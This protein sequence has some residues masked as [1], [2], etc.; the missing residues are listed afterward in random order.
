M[1]DNY[2]ISDILTWLEEKTL[3]VNQQ[4]QRSDQVWTQPAKA[5]LIDT[6]LRGLPMPPIYI[7]TETDPSTRRSFREVVDGQQR[8]L[9]I[10]S[11]VNDEFALG[12]NEEAYGENAGMK[13]SD[14]VPDTQKDFLG[15]QVP[16][17][18]LFNAPDAKVF[19]IFRRLNTY[20]FRLTHQELRHGRYQGHFRNAVLD[21]S[22]KWRVLWDRYG[23][24][25]KRARVRMADDELTAQ[26]FG[27]ILEGVCDG[28]QKAIEKL[29]KSFDSDL[30]V[31]ASLRLDRTVSY[32]LSDMEPALETALSTAPHFLMLFA[33]VA[34]V[35]DGLPAGDIGVE[36][37]PGRLGQIKDIPQALTNL[38]TLAGVLETDLEEVPDRFKEFKEA[39]LA[40]TQRIRSRKVRFLKLYSAL[41]TE[42]I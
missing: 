1:I 9:A 27:V 26:M 16:C 39:A 7:R 10:R 8:V 24:V 28:G 40:S 2:T 22:R 38:Q 4:Y 12:A 42:S 17:E 35:R 14:L 34:H 19:D 13:Y 15:Y 36:M 6:I 30:P 37:P 33:A 21:S 29:Y 20:N 11:F 25:N 5:Y 3:I 41:G 23:I 31:D 32:L 18:Q